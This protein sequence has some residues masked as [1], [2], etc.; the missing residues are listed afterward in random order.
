MEKANSKIL[1]LSF[2]LTGVIVGLTVHLLIKAFA[3][4]FGVVARAAEHDLVRHGLPVVFGLGLFLYMQFTPRILAWG[5][6]VVSEVRKVVFPTR[7]ETTGMTIIVLIF[8]F[9]S[10]VIVTVFDF[11]SAWFINGII[12]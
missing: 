3:G 10:S 5:E 7:K 4:A 8:V 12:K 6:E 9:V 2:A 11:G 1:T